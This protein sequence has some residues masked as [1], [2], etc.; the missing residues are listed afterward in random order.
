M[1]EVGAMAIS[2][3]REGPVVVGGT[4]YNLGQM[5]ASALRFVERHM[6]TVLRPKAFV[7]LKLG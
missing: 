4:T 6:I 7:R 3:L 2:L 1:Y 5:D